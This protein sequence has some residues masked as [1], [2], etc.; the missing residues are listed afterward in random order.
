[1][2]LRPAICRHVMTALP[3]PA[4]KMRTGRHMRDAAAELV[5][6]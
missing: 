1:M 6:G 2:P 5:R 3:G 4:W